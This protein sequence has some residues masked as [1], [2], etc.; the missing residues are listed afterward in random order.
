MN[1]CVGVQVTDGAPD[2]ADVPDEPDASLRL[3]EG[4]QE[5]PEAQITTQVQQGRQ[6][7]RRERSQGL[8]ACRAIAY[9]SPRSIKARCAALAACIHWLRALPTCGS[10]VQAT[11]GSIYSSANKFE[12]LPIS[13]ELLQ[14]ST[15]AHICHTVS[16]ASLQARVC[17]KTGHNTA[18]SVPQGQPKLD[19]H[20]IS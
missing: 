1:A 10:C 16:M 14:V 8:S 3:T 19:W 18:A 4:L 9:C 5:R 6:R 17:S 12:D 20:A 2:G 11:E 7:S 15:S 13:P